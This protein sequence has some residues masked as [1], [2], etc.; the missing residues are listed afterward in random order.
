MPEDGYAKNGLDKSGFNKYGFNVS[1]GT[2]YN[3]FGLDKDELLSLWKTTSIKVDDKIKEETPVEKVVESSDNEKPE[4][5]VE[6]L[7]AKKKAEL[8]GIC[9]DFVT[10][11]DV[12]CKVLNGFVRLCIAFAWICKDLPGFL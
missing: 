4:F 2:K 12:L 10:I 11:L 3:E 7:T 8:Q 1:T 5:T 9:K 6:E